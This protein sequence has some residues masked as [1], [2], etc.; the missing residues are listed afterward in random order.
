MEKIDFCK[1]EKV[2]GEEN[3]MEEKKTNQQSRVA[4][5]EIIIDSV[6]PYQENYQMRMLKNN[7]IPGLLRVSGCGM[8]GASRYYYHTGHSQ[9]LE[10]YY[11]NKDIRAEEILKLT[12]QFLSVMEKMKDY[13]LEPNYLMLSE[14]YIFEKNE[15]YFFCFFPE[16]EKTWQVSYHKLT[17]YFVR[18]VDYQD[19]ESIQLACMLHKETLKETY[20]LESILQQY[21]QKTG[22]KSSKKRRSE[23]KVREKKKE[24]KW[25]KIKTLRYRKTAI[26]TR[27][28][29]I[30]Q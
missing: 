9:S 28:E 1:A 29:R 3:Q 15:N 20:D 11:K 4:E 30:M 7:R 23:K 17:E 22:K 21:E 18:K 6:Q 2:K 8:E 24:E 10:T 12:R 14:K 5:S 16:N 27:R 25:K 26:I 13:M 19:L